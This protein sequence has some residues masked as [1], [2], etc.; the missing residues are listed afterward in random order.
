MLIQELKI[1]VGLFFCKSRK[2]LKL[3]ELVSKE[4]V[5]EVQRNSAADLSRGLSEMH[6]DGMSLTSDKTVETL[7][8]QVMDSARQNARTE[9]GLDEA[10]QVCHPQNI[11]EREDCKVAQDEE[12]EL[13]ELWKICKRNLAMVPLEA[14]AH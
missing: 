1:S 9:I 2:V 8:S 14:S 3:D 4:P 12:I 5:I 13:E 6:I 10:A 11:I 7:N